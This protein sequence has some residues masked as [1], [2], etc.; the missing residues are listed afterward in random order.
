MNR[1]TIGRTLAGTVITSLLFAGMAT[2]A[3]AAETAT[4][5]LGTAEVLTLPD[6]D[7]VRDTTTVT[8]ASDVPTV[9]G[10]AVYNG[11]AWVA[12]LPDVTL[13]PEAL[14]S[15]VTVPVTG[16]PAGAL[17]L[18]ASPE[19]GGSQSTTL[20]VG[21]GEPSTVTTTL[22]ASKIY[23]WS[24]AT[25]RSTTATVTAVDETALAVPFTGTVTATVGGK[26]YKVAVTSA[27]GAPAKAG[28]AV[29]KLA[30]GTGT[31]KATVRAHKTGSSTYSSPAVTLKVL[32]TAVTAVK[33]SAN[34]TT[35]YPK[36]DSYRD[37]V[38]IT[39]TPT[40]TTGTSF[41]STGT[42]KITRNGK[43]IKTWKLTSSKTQSFSW[44]GKVGTKI[45]PGTYT[46]TASLKGPE[47]ATKTTKT[48]IKVSSG[49]LVTKTKTVKYKAHSI[50]KYYVPFDEYEES[51]CA[52][53]IDRV[54]DFGCLGYDA[55]Y[56]DAVSLIGYGSV[57]LPS[58]VITAQ[59]YGTP[60]ASVTLHTTYL[61]GA[62]AWSIDT[63]E[64]ATA[65][66]GSVALGNKTLSSLSLAKGA[67][68][69]YVNVGLGEYSTWVADT[70][71][72]TYTYKVMTY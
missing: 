16:L 70:I 72:V 26:T 47:G 38:K 56:V 3:S 33:L 22:S 67:K 43:T 37:T 45:V 62:A 17:T 46:V 1:S 10:L 2:A 57:A 28:F 7:G 65:K 24:K 60:K 27:T 12:D 29:T 39:L 15:D 4:L 41:A 63:V 31:V 13:T 44:N 19:L 23:T 21:S 40:T 20:T 50:L 8:L 25:P 66:V 5:T 32:K 55:Y 48:T 64:V 6:A 9:V 53:D 34:Y 11:D 59:A 54:G 18:V 68:R 35:V 61:S 14:T 36:V 69:L 30:A 42:V 71:S 58:Y 51:F 49:K 52:Y